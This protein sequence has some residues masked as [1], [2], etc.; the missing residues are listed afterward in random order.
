MHVGQTYLLCI[1]TCWSV[2]HSCVGKKIDKNIERLLQISWEFFNFIWIWFL[3]VLLLVAC[4]P[5]CIHN[6]Y[7]VVCSNNNNNF[8][9][10]NNNR[11]FRLH[12]VASFKLVRPDRHCCAVPLCTLRVHF[13]IA[14]LFS[15]SSSSSPHLQHSN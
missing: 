6:R 3:A 11:W 2:T 10:E 9:V 4:C 5:C 14:Y 8:S 7:K 15:F 12:I 1:Y 13:I